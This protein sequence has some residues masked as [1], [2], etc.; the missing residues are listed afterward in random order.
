MQQKIK[1]FRQYIRDKHMRQV[2]QQRMLADSYSTK[3][4]AEEAERISSLP[5]REDSQEALKQALIYEKEQKDMKNTKRDLV[6]IIKG[7]NREQV[8][9]S[10]KHEFDRVIED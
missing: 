10:R 3:M 8:D 4:H 6:R 7:I 1:D 5:R 9:L 2:Q